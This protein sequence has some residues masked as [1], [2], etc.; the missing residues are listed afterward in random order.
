MLFLVA[1]PAG[2]NA[3][4]PTEQV[5]STIESV[6]RVI[7][8][9]KPGADRR[10]NQPRAQLKGILHARFDFQEMAKRSLGSHWQG[11]SVAQQEEFVELFSGFLERAY[12]DQIEAYAGGKVIYAGESEDQSYAQVDTKIIT[13]KG[14]EV[15]V[16]YKLRLS[17]RDWKVYDVIVDNISLVSNYRSQFNRV[18]TG[19]SFEELT[20]MLKAKI[21]GG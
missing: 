10:S 1:L 6:L 20:R 9:S 3:G 8:D 18:I 14:E 16:D 4:E 15:S 5:R 13:K 11:R 17:G 7:D 2:L 21:E 12:L 19:S